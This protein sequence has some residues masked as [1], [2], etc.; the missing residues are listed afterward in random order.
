[1]SQVGKWYISPLL[2]FSRCFW[3]TN[4]VQ[5]RNSIGF[6]LA[7]PPI[8]TSMPQI[9]ELEWKWILSVVVYISLNLLL[10]PDHYKNAL[11]EAFWVHRDY[12]QLRIRVPLL[13]RVCTYLSPVHSYPLGKD[14]RRFIIKQVALLLHLPSK[15]HPSD[16]TSAMSN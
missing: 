14:E 2:H 9:R 8:I 6:H 1:M 11:Y 13:A 16:L 12:H 5:K 7:L 15:S 3:C 4:F 10:L